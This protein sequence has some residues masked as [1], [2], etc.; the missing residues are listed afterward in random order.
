MITTE[1]D[2]VVRY[3]AALTVSDQ[4][5]ADNYFDSLGLRRI[6]ND[7]GLPYRL[8]CLVEKTNLRYWAERAGGNA[9]ARAKKLYRLL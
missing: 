3:G 9:E 1:Q 7:P 4:E 2:E 5:A 6:D 8:A